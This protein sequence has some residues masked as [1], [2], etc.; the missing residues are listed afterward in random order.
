LTSA[1]NWFIAFDVTLASGSVTWALESAFPKLIRENDLPVDEQRLHQALLVAQE[2]SSRE[3]DF[4]PLLDELFETMGW[5]LALKKRLV[6]DI[7]NS[8]Q[9]ELFD[10]TLPF[11]ERLRAHNRRVFI[12]SNNPLSLKFIKQLEIEGA[13]DGMYAPVLHPG[14]RPKPH[15]DLWDIISVDAGVQPSNSVMVGDDPWADGQF[16]DNCGLPCWIVDRKA[17][18]SHLRAQHAYG[19]VRTLLEIPLAEDR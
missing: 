16:A 13:I 17:R 9:P 6:E 12:L 19:W 7:F 11:L 18:F 10:D 2:R 14:A 8:Y 5:P 4:G 15:R 1:L 3:T